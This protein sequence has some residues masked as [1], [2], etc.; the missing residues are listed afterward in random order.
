M[1]YP[2]TVL[3]ASTT[4]P[5]PSPTSH[6]NLAMALP[7]AGQATTTRARRC[8]VRALDRASD[9][10]VSVEIADRAT[11]VDQPWRAVAQAT[12]PA[13]LANPVAVPSKKADPAAHF[14]V[15]ARVIMSDLAAGQ[16][17]SPIGPSEISRRDRV[18]TKAAATSAQASPPPGGRGEERAG[19]VASVDNPSAECKPQGSLKRLLLPNLAACVGHPGY[20]AA[21]CP[22]GAPIWQVPCGD[23]DWQWV[24]ADGRASVDLRPDKLRDDPA[25]WWDALAAHDIHT[26]SVLLCAETLGW[27]HWWHHHMPDPAAKP[28]PGSRAADGVVG[29]A[30]CG[31]PMQLVPAGWRCRKSG[32]VFPFTAHLTTHL[33]VDLATEPDPESAVTKCHAKTRTEPAP[34]VVS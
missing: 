11:S 10:A 22:S 33:N 7:T 34:M 25:G 14:H 31:W 19:R 16:V 17:A 1:R 15:G 23:V 2:V 4:R 24:D 32:R 20:G 30:C 29:P 6:A 5:H 12:A 13:A 3:R 21:H 8:S 9:P 26:Y 28:A 27:W 18:R